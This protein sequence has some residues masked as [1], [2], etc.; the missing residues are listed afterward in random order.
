M[1]THQNPRAPGASLRALALSLGLGLLLS[2][3]QAPPR[4]VDID[5]VAPRNFLGHVAARCLDPGIANYCSR[6]ALPQAGA[7]CGQEAACM[8]R[9]DLWGQTAEFF[10][11]R[12]AK[13]C[14][15]PASFVHG[16]VLPKRPV[17]GV[18]DPSRPDGI[19]EWAWQ[20]GAQRISPQNLALVV[21][22]PGQRSQDQLHVH[23]VA[24]QEGVR[25]QLDRE[26]VGIARL[27][28]AWSAAQRAADQRGWRDY[29]VLVTQASQGG[30]QVMVSAQSPEKA[31]TQYRCE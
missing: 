7:A 14:G 30:W 23:L 27:D 2:A 10:A 28:Q 16:L 25:P 6:C 18:E 26:S 1:S 8:K 21:N 3:C 13:E 11:M 19:W 20:V 5:P 29:G 9:L 22:P 4:A 15:C 17:T 24:L 31:F 12:D